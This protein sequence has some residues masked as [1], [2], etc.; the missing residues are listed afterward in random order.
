VNALVLD[1]VGLGL[2]DDTARGK[3]ANNGGFS[4]MNAAMLCQGATLGE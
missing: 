3:V 4:R 2:A 1:E